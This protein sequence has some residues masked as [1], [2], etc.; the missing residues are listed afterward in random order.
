MLNFIHTNFQMM[1]SLRCSDFI[2]H[3]ITPFCNFNFA[4]INVVEHHLPQ[5]SRP[6]LAEGTYTAEQTIQVSDLAN[7][8]GKCLHHVIQGVADYKD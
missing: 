8:T 1:S 2:T 3:T 7:Y 6:S 4:R 5:M